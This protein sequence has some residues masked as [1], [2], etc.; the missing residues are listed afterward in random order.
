MYCSDCG[1]PRG[2]GKANTWKSSGVIV[3]KYEKDLRGIF[4]DVGELENLFTSLSQVIGYDV[5]RL[6]IEGKRKDSAHYTRGL[7]RSIEDSGA[8][9]PG[10]EDFFRIMAA[11]YCV[12]GFGKVNIISY[13]D[14]ESIELEMECV[15][16]IPMAQGQ[17]AGVFEAVLNRRGDV[18]WEGDTARGRVTVTVREEEPEL[19]KRIESEVEAP[20]CLLDCGEKEYELCR[21]CSAP[22]ELCR[23]FDWDVEKATI[24]ERRSGRRF[25]F[26]NTRGITAVMRVLVEEL[27]EDVERTIME[28]SRDY[29]RDYY[30]GI[31]ERVALD[32]EFARLSLWGWG[33]P[34]RLDGPNG[35]HRLRIANPFYGPVMAGRAWGL[36]E[37]SSGKAFDL[38]EHRSGESTVLL[39]LSAG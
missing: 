12:P 30:L 31:S 17:A 24:T 1:M 4:Y 18:S 11:N 15:Y 36:V 27:G 39:G 2:I 32:P 9:L 10:P 25:I 37:A 26:D 34:S 38:D 28:I 13:R 7:L 16:S 35:D 29:A 6:V 33:L 20:S 22:A 14:G 19:E 21:R 5:T 8:Q 23:E 3:S